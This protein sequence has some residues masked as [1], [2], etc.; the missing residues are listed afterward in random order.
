M[1]SLCCLDRFS[2][3]L[4]AGSEDQCFR[5][6]QD[7][8]ERAA[9]VIDFINGGNLKTEKSRGSVALSSH[10]LYTWRDFLWGFEA[11][12]IRACVGCQHGW[13]NAFAFALAAPPV[14]ISNSY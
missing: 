2:D 9:G 10:A 13:D 12:P 5:V 7:R 3:K 6:F 8:P 1:I 11:A 4:I 14:K